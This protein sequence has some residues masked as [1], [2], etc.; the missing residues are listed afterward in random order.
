ML[1]WKC[2]AHTRSFMFKS[3]HSGLDEEEQQVEISSQGC[4]GDVES[5]QQV[6]NK[7]SRFD[8]VSLSLVANPRQ[9]F[10]LYSVIYRFLPLSCSS[11]PVIA[12]M[13]GHERSGASQ[14]GTERT[15]LRFCVR[16]H[17]DGVCHHGDTRWTMCQQA[18][19]SF[20]NY[21]SFILT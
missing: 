21:E 15:I 17:R 13:D 19:N 12:H 3:N 10:A 11:P 1:L 20:E 18:W 9:L 6:D 5:R 16:C 8:S 4:H 2:G 14:K 7:S